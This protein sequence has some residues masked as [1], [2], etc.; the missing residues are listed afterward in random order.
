MKYSERELMKR[1]ILIL[2]ALAITVAGAS[3]LAF[4]EDDYIVA[5]PMGINVTNPFNPEDPD[6]DWHADGYYLESEVEDWTPEDW[7]NYY[8][9]FPQAFPSDHDPRYFD[10]ADN[11]AREDDSDYEYTGPALEGLSIDF[12]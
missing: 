12:E 7:D 9:E 1:V 4:K 10:P 6:H 8:A 2:S 11:S 3:A 5:E